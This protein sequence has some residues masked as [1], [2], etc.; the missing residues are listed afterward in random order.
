MACQ[1]FPVNNPPLNAISGPYNT[2]SDCEQGC[3]VSG[4]CCQ[5][6]P[7][8]CIE[9]TAE[10]CAGAGGDYRGDGSRC[11]EECPPVFGACCNLSPP[12]EPC[13]QLQECDCDFRGGTY[14]GDLTNCGDCPTVCPAYPVTCYRTGGAANSAGYSSVEVQCVDS[15]GIRVFD[16]RSHNGGATTGSW[17][18]AGC[19]ASAVGT[20]AGPDGASVSVCWGGH[21]ISVSPGNLTCCAAFGGGGIWCNEQI[22]SC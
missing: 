10:E 7:A 2:L 22:G 14:Q 6:C 16:G 5:T 4:A 20:I 1:Q 21:C 9:V 8:I 3:V 12:N 15:N 17:S 18:F 19:G 11:Q 13:E